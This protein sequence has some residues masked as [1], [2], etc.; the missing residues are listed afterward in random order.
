MMDYLTKAG[1]AKLMPACTYPIT[2]MA[3]VSRIYSDLALIELTRQ[4]PVVVELA[5]GL[6]LVTLRTLRPGVHLLAADTL[7]EAA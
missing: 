6:S 1:E 3:C 7:K 2:G 5:P 4:G